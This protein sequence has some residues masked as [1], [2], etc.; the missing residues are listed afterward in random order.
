MPARNTQT[1]G[2][3]GTAAHPPI[4]T[5]SPGE[6]RGVQRALRAVEGLRCGDQQSGPVRRGLAKIRRIVPG[7]RVA[8]APEVAADLAPLRDFLCESARHGPDVDALAGRLEQQGY[9][10]AQIAAL[11]MIAG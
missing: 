5:L 11:S 3:S 9:S 7:M 6:W 2:D 10:P 8:V 4:P 1:R